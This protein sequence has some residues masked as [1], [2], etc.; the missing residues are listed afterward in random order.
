MINDDQWSVISFWLAICKRERERERRKAGIHRLI[1]GMFGV[2]VWCLVAGPRGGHHTYRDRDQHRGLHPVSGGERRAEPLRAGA[3]GI[4]NIS[5]HFGCNHQ[6]SVSCE[7]EKKTKYHPCLRCSL[8]RASVLN[9]IYIFWSPFFPLGL[10][11]ITVHTR[12]VLRGRDFF[13][14]WGPHLKDHPPIRNQRHEIGP[15]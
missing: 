11:P 8:N 9:Q 15:N 1:A 10:S 13:F 4:P 7:F 12:A 6:A 5:V 3:A 2:C 14:R